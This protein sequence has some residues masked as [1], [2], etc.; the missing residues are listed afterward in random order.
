M[1]LTGDPEADLVYCNAPMLP[2]RG[3]DSLQNCG[4]ARLGR[5]LG[6]GIGEEW[7]TVLRKVGQR[8]WVWIRCQVALFD[9][10][11]DADDFIVPFDAIRLPTPEEKLSDTA[12]YLYK[13]ELTAQVRPHASLPRRRTRAASAAC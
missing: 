9:D 3:G 2:A 13:L 11:F 5:V 10:V 7:N 12:T 1:P 4:Q 6:F 8:K